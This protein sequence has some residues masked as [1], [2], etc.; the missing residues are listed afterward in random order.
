MKGRQRA[1]CPLCRT[2]INT[3]EIK[4]VENCSDIENKFGRTACILKDCVDRLWPEPGRTLYHSVDKNIVFIMDELHKRNMT[5]H[6]L[7]NSM[8]ILEKAEMIWRN[9]WIKG[10]GEVYDNDD[11]DPYD[12]NEDN[13]DD[14]TFE[15]FA[16]GIEESREQ[17]ANIPDIP[18]HDL[19]IVY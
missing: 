15:E 5:I 13:D 12:D 6:A 8:T 17:L 4:D 9:L 11:Y 7:E 19:L 14:I 1:S 16:R 10:I 18:D 3:L 2:P